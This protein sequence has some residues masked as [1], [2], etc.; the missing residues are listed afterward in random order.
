MENAGKIASNNTLIAVLL[1]IFVSNIHISLMYQ[2]S[3]GTTYELKSVLVLLYFVQL[4]EKQRLQREIYAIKWHPKT[5]LLAV[6][7][8]TSDGKGT[9]N[10]LQYA[11]N[12][13]SRVLSLKVRPTHTTSGYLQYLDAKYGFRFLYISG[14]QCFHPV[15]GK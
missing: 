8:G 7:F 12:D 6:G 5:A 3:I 1:C 10:C 13:F 2:C 9:I 15:M 14:G 11:D 4:Q